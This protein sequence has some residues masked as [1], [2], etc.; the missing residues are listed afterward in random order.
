[1]TLLEVKTF[2]SSDYK[3]AAVIGKDRESGRKAIHF[4]AI[5]DNDRSYT[6]VKRTYHSYE[7]YEELTKLGEDYVTKRYKIG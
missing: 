5:N 2:Y 7:N 1:M 3:L 4:Y 6:E